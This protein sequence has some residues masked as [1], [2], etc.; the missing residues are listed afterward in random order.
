M[1]YGP[2]E[3]DR[4]PTA[5]SLTRLLLVAA[6][7]VP[8]A[9]IIVGAFQLGFVAALVGA[10]LWIP[11]VLAFAIAAFISLLLTARF[12]MKKAW[13][14]SLLA[15][16]LPIVLFAVAL[17]PRGFLFA[18]D[19]IGE[20]ARFIALKPSYDRQVS[21]LPENQR[22]GPVIFVWD[23]FLGAS[24]GVLYDATDQV[25]LPPG[26]QS[27]EWLERA[28]HNAEL[29]AAIGDQRARCGYSVRPLWDHYYLAGFWC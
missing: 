21:G 27:R 29:A 8:L 15:A 17:N 22:P 2:D 16:V 25:T 7:C 4:V 20:V 28:S 5:V 14:S 3:F 6:L 9:P 1:R 11:V 23:G 26:H 18:C 10:I 12:A 13:K 19:H 24:N